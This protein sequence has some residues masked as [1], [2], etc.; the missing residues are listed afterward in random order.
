MKTKQ[1]E[2]T[3]ANLQ[4]LLATIKTNI[5]GNDRM[6]VFY[7]GIKSIDWDEVAFP[8]F[9]PEACQ[10][11]WDEMSRK[12]RKFRTLTELIVEAEDVISDPSQNQKIH[13][14][15]PKTPLTPSAMFYKENVAK[16][17]EKKPKLKQR[18]LMTLVLK[19]YKA[20]PREEKAKYVKKYQLTKE[21]Y[22]KSM[23]KF[24]EQYEDAP[25]HGEKRKNVSEHIQ[26]GNKRQAKSGKTFPGE[27]KM[28]PR[29]ANLI[30]YKERLKKTNNSIARTSEYDS[31]IH[32]MWKDLP[33]REKERYKEQCDDLFRK[34][35]KKLQNWFKTLTTAEQE[36]YR[37]CN[38][39]K[40]KYLDDKHFKTNNTDMNTISDSEDEDIEY[41]SSDEGEDE[42]GEE[43]EEDGDDDDDDDIIMFEIY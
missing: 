22:E 8:P 5:S 13:P 15:L 20:L 14:E 40:C 32:H 19:E 42:E 4:R 7:Q 41:S 23:E 35:S 33:N 29:A 16:F 37:I 1:S 3:K 21:E 36:G 34:Y 38:P 9:S 12:M 24:R 28:P 10:K 31:N 26:N 39:S 6:R 30:F 17:H 11:K 27:P 25:V 43:E 2:W 18:E